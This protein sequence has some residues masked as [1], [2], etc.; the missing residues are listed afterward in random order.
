MNWSRRVNQSEIVHLKRNLAR[1]Q[2]PSRNTRAAER[3]KMHWP[4]S[5]IIQ[6]SSSA[7][8]V[9][10][11]AAHGSFSRPLDRRG[12]GYERGRRIL[13]EMRPSLRNIFDSPARMHCVN[14]HREIGL[15][16]CAGLRGDSIYKTPPVY[17]LLFSAGPNHKTIMLAGREA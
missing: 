17:I 4:D 13:R 15:S 9:Y 7:T 6:I 5:T 12:G 16:P 11:T 3:N 2:V 14:S 8:K 1:N 10:P